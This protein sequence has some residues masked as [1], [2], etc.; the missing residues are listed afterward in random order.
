[1]TGDKQCSRNNQFAF[2]STRRLRASSLVERL[3]YMKAQAIVTQNSGLASVGSS[4]LDRDATSGSWYVPPCSHSLGSAAPG[5][6]DLL[7]LRKL[8]QSAKGTRLSG[9]VELYEDSP[10][11]AFRLVG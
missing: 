2:T 10:K 5:G 3:N 11:E 4:T 9:E 8:P 1:M 6:D 7:F